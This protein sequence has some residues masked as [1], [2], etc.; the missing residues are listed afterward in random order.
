MPDGAKLLVAEDKALTESKRKELA[1]TYSGEA[2]AILRQAV[3]AG[4]TDLNF[5]KTTEAFQPLR[6]NEEFK[7]LLTD[8]ET[9]TG[10]R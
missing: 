7:K 9:K 5:L 8:L 10:K 2:L 6:S 3:N 1:R 4:F